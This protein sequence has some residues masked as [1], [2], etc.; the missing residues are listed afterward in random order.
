M[1][2]LTAVSD[3]RKKLGDND[4]D[5][6]SWR[7][8]I[9]GVLNGNNTAFKT[10]EWRRV[11]DFTLL[12]A[13]DTSVLGVFVNNSKVSVTSDDLTSGQFT[14][15]DA[16]E[17]GD[18]IQATYYN[19]WFV[20]DELDSFLRSACNFLGLGDD[21]TEIE[22][23]LRPAAL[24]YAGGDAFKQLALRWRQLGEMYRVEDLPRQ[25]IDQFIKDYNDAA[26]KDY[27]MATKKR[28]DFYDGRQGQAM[29]PLSSNIVG[30]VWDPQPKR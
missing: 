12:S 7:K 14:V 5:K 9:F 30:T 2:W 16:P 24:E 3:L 20:D 21:Y 13:S 23:G 18:T 6:L 4:M 17:N 8:T 10:Y 28:N 11:T 26:V 15:S 22:F 1:A 27:D 19:Q 25:G 29:Q